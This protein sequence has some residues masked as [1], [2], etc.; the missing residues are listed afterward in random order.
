MTS[1]GEIS[2]SNLLVLFMS[3]LLTRNLGSIANLVKFLRLPFTN[4]PLVF[5]DVQITMFSYVIATNKQN[6]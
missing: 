5:T 6:Y 2:S 4:V 1:A 3:D